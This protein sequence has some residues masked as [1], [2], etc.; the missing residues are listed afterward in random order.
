MAEG[1]AAAE[2]AV[3]IDLTGEGPV[4]PP[5]T[6]SRLVAA[7][8]WRAAMVEVFGFEGGWD[9]LLQVCGEW[10]AGAFWRCV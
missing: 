5:E 6:P 9:M 1:G 8:A 3:E 2:G 7:A 10:V 4:P